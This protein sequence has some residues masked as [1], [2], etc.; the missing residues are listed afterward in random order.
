MAVKSTDRPMLGKFSLP[1]QILK[2]PL[3]FHHRLTV[4]LASGECEILLANSTLVMP[5]VAADVAFTGKGTAI[6]CCGA[7]DCL[8]LVKGVLEQ[9]TGELLFPWQD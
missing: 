5:L 7:G 4:L 3:G 8:P 6:F 2:I 1:L 9:R